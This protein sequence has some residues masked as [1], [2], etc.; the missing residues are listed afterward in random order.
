MIVSGLSNRSPPPSSKTDYLKNDEANKAVLKLGLIRMEEGYVI[1]GPYTVSSLPQ[2]GVVGA[3]ALEDGAIT[4]VG[5]DVSARH[6]RIYK[7][8]DAWYAQDLGSTNGTH[9]SRL[10]DGT[11]LDISAGMPIELH[12]GDCV[13]LG[14]S[15]NFAV[16]AMSPDLTACESQGEI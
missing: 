3:L 2:G 14:S 7:Q 11:Y 15:T 13:R 1:G 6:L 12:P 16:V 5:L 10:S 8:G 4:N 9:L